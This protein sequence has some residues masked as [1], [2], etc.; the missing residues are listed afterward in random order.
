MNQMAAHLVRQHTGFIEELEGGPA[1]P[2]HRDFVCAPVWFLDLCGAPKRF[3]GF[4]DGVHFF[5]FLI[6]VKGKKKMFR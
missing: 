3:L 6:R 4:A 5:L 1:Y 2:V